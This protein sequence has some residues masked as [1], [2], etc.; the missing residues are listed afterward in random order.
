MKHVAVLLLGYDA[1]K[2]SYTHHSLHGLNYQTGGGYWL[3][4]GEEWSDEVDATKVM[5]TLS[6]AALAR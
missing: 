5:I 6:M 4:G 1:M 2:Q 3:R